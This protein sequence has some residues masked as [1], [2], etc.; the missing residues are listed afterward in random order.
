M[1]KISADPITEAAVKQDIRKELRRLEIEKIKKHGKSDDS[2]E[3]NSDVMMSSG[4]A[5]GD[6][7]Q[8]KSDVKTKAAGES[9]KAA[10]E[11][12]I[13]DDHVT[14]TENID[15]DANESPK[16]SGNADECPQSRELSAVNEEVNVS[17]KAFK[18]TESI[19]V[20]ETQQGMVDDVGVFKSPPPVQKLTTLTV[21]S[22]FVQNV[23]AANKTVIRHF[24][25]PRLG[26][27]IDRFLL[28]SPTEIEPLS[29]DSGA[30][31][32]ESSPISRYVRTHETFVGINPYS[33]PA[34]TVEATAASMESSVVKTSSEKV[35]RLSSRLM[36]LFS[37]SGTRSPRTFTT[38]ETTTTNTILSHTHSDASTKPFVAKSEALPVEFH[39][40]SVDTSIPMTTFQRSE[41]LEQPEQ[42]SLC[43]SNENL[44]D[45]V[46]YF[47]T[48]ITNASSPTPGDTTTDILDNGGKIKEAACFSQLPIAS[49]LAVSDSSYRCDQK[50]PKDN[51]QQNDATSVQTSD[52]VVMCGS[53]QNADSVK[54]C[55]SM[56]GKLNNVVPEL[57][58]SSLQSETVETY[59]TTDVTPSVMPIESYNCEDSVPVQIS[60]SNTNDT[61]AIQTPV[62]GISQTGSSDVDCKTFIAEMFT[63]S[64]APRETPVMGE[65]HG[66]Y[67]SDVSSMETP[68]AK[69]SYDVHCSYIMPSETPLERALYGSYS[70]SGLLH[71][72]RSIT[73][74]SY[75]AYGGDASGNTPV[76]GTTYGAHD[77]YIMPTQISGSGAS[78]GSYSSTD[79][80]PSEPP[81]TRASYGV[82]GRNLVSTETPIIGA[83]NEVCTSNA[84]YEKT[85]VTGTYEIYDMY[86]VPTETLDTGVSNEMY[87][88]DIV[89]NEAAAMESSSEIYDTDPVD[90]QKT[91]LGESY[92]NDTLSQ[93]A[94][95]TGAFTSLTTSNESNTPPLPSEPS[96][97][98]PP[99]PPSAPPSISANYS[100]MCYGHTSNNRLSSL[101][102]TS[103]KP[104]VYTYSNSYYAHGISL[105]SNYGTAQGASESYFFDGNVSS[106]EPSQSNTPV[107]S[108]HEN[109][110]LV[111]H[112]TPT[113]NLLPPPPP[114][115]LP[116]PP[117]PPLPEHSSY[118]TPVFHLDDYSE[119]Y[120][121]LYAHPYSGAQPQ[122]IS[123]SATTSYPN[124]SSSLPKDFD[125]AAGFGYTKQI[126]PM[127]KESSCFKNNED[128]SFTRKDTDSKH[129]GELLLCE[130]ATSTKNLAIQNNHSPSKLVSKTD[131]I[132]KS[133][134]KKREA[135]NLLKKKSSVSKSMRIKHHSETLKH[136]EI[137]ERTSEEDVLSAD[138]MHTH[139]ISPTEITSTQLEVQKDTMLVPKTPCGLDK[140]SSLDAAP[141]NLEPGE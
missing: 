17:G 57:T 83:A 123:A 91:I 31:T 13:V 10:K 103:T 60:G 39:N 11:G 21:D 110:S 52:A 136:K 85:P 1:N 30:D 9:T 111:F 22:M 18:D 109:T 92:G 2:S 59:C 87:N 64:G 108:M 67:D 112:Y 19:P 105:S 51:P 5:Q 116:P 42:Y 68:L 102:S 93:Q 44:S 40:V 29:S 89:L 90:T 135:Y 25:D 32:P 7:E 76:A 121:S 3:S 138:G 75:E 70:N 74:A 104:E 6:A 101:I 139:S 34:I 133:K 99:P 115:P 15:K 55:N 113:S 134:N 128:Q 127:W 24:M 48:K 62:V 27:K 82:Y 120:S 137:S 47:Q 16:T 106:M 35:S 45:I 66:T 33:D 141:S 46:T 81:V 12:C 94:S 73:R 41:T 14:E 125:S 77:R 97:P 71:S 72:E 132:L 38:V 56:D 96:P 61:E 119:S 79:V 107:V 23:P 126:T 4:H 69:A 37:Q 98:P 43:I 26:C 140:A 122:C 28:T 80:A 49:N 8:K 58:I 131:M 78:C 84:M 54:E 118:N 124:L 65:S 36:A 129:V 86:T 20:T 63:A 130:E 50:S 53:T 117:P 95:V 100:N 88:G 114:P